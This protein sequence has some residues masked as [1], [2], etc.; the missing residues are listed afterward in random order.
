MKKIISC[1]ILLVVLCAALN[2]CGSG[3]VEDEQAT[4]T[5]FISAD[6]SPSMSPADGGANGSKDIIIENDMGTAATPS[7]AGG[8]ASPSPASTAKP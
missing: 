1:V 8:T 7:G 3:R 2:G 4:A 5:P 6:I